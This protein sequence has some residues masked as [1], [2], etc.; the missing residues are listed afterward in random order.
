MNGLH[1]VHHVAFA[2]GD[3]DRTVRFWRDLIGLR[4]VYASGRPGYR[5]YFFEIGSRAYVA[6]FEWP[7]VQRI[8][9]R[10]HG[11]PVSGPFVF[12]HLCLAVDSEERLWTLVGAFSAAE[13][14]VSDVIDHGFIRSIY[15]HDPN[16]IPIEFCWEVPGLDPRR[17]PRVTDREPSA[18]ARE[19]A[20]P[21]P[22]HWPAAEPIP[23]DERIV[24]PGDGRADFCRAD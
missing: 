3:M 9:P 15:S 5:Q 13:L 19:G 22:G 21:V 2:T 10:T 14:P 17:A 12:D 23:A 11:A 18:T 20:E 7:D 8:K 4:L 1:G 6:F 16:G 24:L